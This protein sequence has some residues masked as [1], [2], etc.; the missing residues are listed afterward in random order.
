MIQNKREKKKSGER[1]PKVEAWF[2]P[3]DGKPLWQ[4]E[5]LDSS[6]TKV[7]RWVKIGQT[8]KGPHTQ[9]IVFCL[10]IIIYLQKTN[11]Q[12]IKILEYVNFANIEEY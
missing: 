3:I 12:N 6:V 10:F 7:Q 8:S 9:K 4:V 5:A 2:T 1:R 11:I